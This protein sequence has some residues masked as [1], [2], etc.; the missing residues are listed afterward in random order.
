MYI[1]YVHNIQF[2]CLDE[3]A[4]PGDRAAPGALMITDK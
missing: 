1:S 2:I 4:T 3:D